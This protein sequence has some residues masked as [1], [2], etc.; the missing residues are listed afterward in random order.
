MN[1]NNYC[2][3]YKVLWTYILDSE[4]KGWD[5][6]DILSANL[7]RRS[8]T[9]SSHKTLINLTQFGRISTFNFRPFFKIKRTIHSKAMA[10]LLAAQLSSEC[11]QNTNSIELLKNLLIYSKSK[12]FT[13]YTLGFPFEIV[14]KSYCSAKG[15]PSLIITLF[16]MYSF[17]Q[18][19]K[20]KKDDEV[21]KIIFS[22][23][24]LLHNK[25][26]KFEDIHTLWYSYNFEKKNEIYNATAKVGKFYA[27][28]YQITND[29]K[30]LSQNR[31]NLELLESKTAI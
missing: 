4:L 29:N 31:K 8:V 15:A 28:L 22:F 17:I 13:D 10:L 6:Y 2:Q 12:K 20:R 23:N 3:I 18:Y 27:L 11:N 7:I 19:W 5:P 24:R 14:L 9:N 25:Y 26:P 21:L 16:G 1:N 30:L